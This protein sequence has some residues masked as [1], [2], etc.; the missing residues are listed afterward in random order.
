MGWN[1]CTG[2]MFGDKGVLTAQVEPALHDT[3]THQCSCSTHVAGR[4]FDNVLGV[5]SLSS[6][7]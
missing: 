4:Y 1:L 6:F 7:L 2:I 3:A 5:S